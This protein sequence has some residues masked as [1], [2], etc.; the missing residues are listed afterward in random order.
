[1]ARQLENA[2]FILRRRR[3]T[4]VMALKVRKKQLQLGFFC[5]TAVD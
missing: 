4:E 3:H 2:A 1:L 5:I